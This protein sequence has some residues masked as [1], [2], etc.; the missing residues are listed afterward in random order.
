MVEIFITE[1]V[2]NISLNVTENPELVS[3]NITETTEQIN[4]LVDESQIGLQGPPGLSGGSYIHNQSVASSEWLIPHNLGFYPN[5]TVMDSTK[6]K[7][8]TDI[9]YID[10][11]NLKIIATAA[12]AGNAYLS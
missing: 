6:R 4:I 9:E 11:N 10:N 7:V 1:T 3:V 5:V 2:E 8:L 12:F